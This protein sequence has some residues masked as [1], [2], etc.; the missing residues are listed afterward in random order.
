MIRGHYIFCVATSVSCTY[1]DLQTSKIH[2]DFFDLY[3]IFFQLC[4]V[5][6]V[7]QFVFSANKYNWNSNISQ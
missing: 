6:L 5:Q 2:N 1:S 7:K 4:A 3:K